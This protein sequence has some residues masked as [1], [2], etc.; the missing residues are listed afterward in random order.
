MMKRVAHDLGLLVLRLAVGGFMAFSHGWSKFLKLM[1]DPQA[2]VDPF[3]LGPEISLGLVV[4]A[5]TI[6]AGLIVVGAAT[7]W[8]AFPLLFAMGVAAF[9]VHGSDPFSGKELALLYAAGA[10]TLMLTGAGRYSVDAWWAA[11][12]A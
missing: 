6:C 2:F 7:R 4:F 5:E 10:L 12:K 9:V 1:D 8:A 11:R 3:G